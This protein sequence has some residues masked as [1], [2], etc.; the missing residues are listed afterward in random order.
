M[1]SRNIY[2]SFIN[3]VP[4]AE[5]LSRVYVTWAPFFNWQTAT[6]YST[7][8]E[9]LQRHHSYKGQ[10]PCIKLCS[11]PL[12][13]L[14]TS[15]V[16]PRHG[17]VMLFVN[18]KQIQIYSKQ[19]S[20]FGYFTSQERIMLSWPHQWQSHNHMSWST[21]SVYLEFQ[22]LLFNILFWIWIKHCSIIVITRSNFVIYSWVH[23]TFATGSNFLRVLFPDF[24][25]NCFSV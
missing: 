8:A 12:G 6:L 11:V 3:F 1:F 19:T 18:Y 21:F 9:S 14:F 16:S 22:K 17:N 24:L 10:P 25:V 5:F 13:M 20:C 2:I 4:R 7:E 15:R 23:P